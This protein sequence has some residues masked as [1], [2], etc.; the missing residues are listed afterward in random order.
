MQLVYDL[1]DLCLASK[2]VDTVPLCIQ[3]VPEQ[4]HQL[5]DVREVFV[6]L[7]TELL[8]DV[9][10]ITFKGFQCF[11]HQRQCLSGCLNLQPSLFN[12]LDRLF[13]RFRL[14]RN[15]LFQVQ[16]AQHVYLLG[17]EIIQRFFARQCFYLSGYVIKS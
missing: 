16:V 13:Q 11:L 15:F 4:L 5:F 2:D 1:I 3:L 6:C 17:D 8:L 12:R 10:G 14:L 9:F 7:I